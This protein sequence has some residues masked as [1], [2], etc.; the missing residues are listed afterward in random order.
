MKNDPIK[1]LEKWEKESYAWNKKYHALKN[2]KEK[3]IAK[4]QENPFRI[5]EMTEETVLF[6][7]K[8]L[9][10]KEVASIMEKYGIRVEDVALVCRFREKIHKPGGPMFVGGYCDTF[11]YAKVLKDPAGNFWEL[12]KRYLFGGPKDNLQVL[13][14]CSKN[15]QYYVS[16]IIFTFPQRKAA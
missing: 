11:S 1:E 9:K 13:F 14:E 15:N 16:G 4:I 5:L 6:R 7:K 10:N 3:I 2:Q 12:T 8:A